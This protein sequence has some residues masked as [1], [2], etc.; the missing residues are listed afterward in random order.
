MMREGQDLEIAGL[1]RWLP[2]DL[3]RDRGELSGWIAD[4]FGGGSPDPLVVAIADGL[5][6]IAQQAKE[7][8]AVDDSAGMLTLGLWVLLAEPGRLAPQSLATLRLVRH[9]DPD[10]LSLVAHLT[11]GAELWE[12]PELD[13]LATASG[14]ALT[15]RVRTVLDEGG[16]RRIHEQ[17]VVMW[18]RA[19]QGYAGVLSTYHEDLLEGTTV[20]EPLLK[21]AEGVKGL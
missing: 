16:E 12:T 5:G 20:A 19:E 18:L 1:E 14:D 21:L 17:L 8:A 15:T 7:R 13:V 9:T 3:E 6:E 10:P 2:L 11:Q 4:H